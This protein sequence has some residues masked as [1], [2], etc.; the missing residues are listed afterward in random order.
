MRNVIVLFFFSL[1][2]YGCVF[3]DANTDQD[4]DSKREVIAFPVKPMLVNSGDEDYGQ[5]DLRLSY[6]GITHTITSITYSVLAEYDHKQIGFNVSIPKKAPWKAIFSGTG[7]ISDNFI[8]VLQKLYKQKIDTASKFTN[9][10]SAD[11][12]SMGDYIDSLHKQDNGNYVAT[13]QN[14]LFFQGKS[15]DEYAELYLNINE[16]EHWIELAEKDRD[17]RAQ[18]IKFLTRSK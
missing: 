2:Y 15:D 17:Y 8:H 4:P 6:T 9:E 16:A 14:K 7:Q 5:A 3:P 11:C 13:A 10:V 18:I 1:M 12:M